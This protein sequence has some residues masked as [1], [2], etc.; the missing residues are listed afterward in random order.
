MRRPLAV[1]LLAVALA[2][3]GAATAGVGPFAEP[4]DVRITDEP[5]DGVLWPFLNDSA[6]T[7]ETIHVGASASGGSEAVGFVVENDGPDTSVPLTVVH[8]PTNETIVDRTISMP[9]DTAAVIVFHRPAAYRVTVDTAQGTA[10]Y[11]V[12]R[13]AFDCNDRSLGVRIEEGGQTAFTS[14]STS[15]A[16]P[17]LPGEPFEDTLTVGPAQ[18]FE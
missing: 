11:P 7:D 15:M 14:I 13:S 12:E 9:T 18:V 5:P 1:A 17:S 10:V 16:C 8:R 2:T 4:P 6:R 3:A